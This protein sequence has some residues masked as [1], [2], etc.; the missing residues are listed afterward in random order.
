MEN[1][2]ALL[3]KRSPWDVFINLLAVIALYVC[4]YAV[5]EMLLSFIALAFPDSLDWQWY[6]PRATIR[7]SLALIIIFFPAYVWS[8]RQIETDLAANPE[9]RRWWIRTFPLYLT[10]F[11]AGLLILGDLA[12]F[13][14]SFLNG[15]LTVRFLFK[16]LAILIVGATVM[17]F[18]R[19]ALR[20]EPGPTRGAML[21]FV[22]CALGVVLI[23]VVAGFATTGSPFKTRLERLDA[24][25]L[26]DL[27]EI[28]RHVRDYSREMN[29]LPP[30]IDEVVSSGYF[31]GTSPT[32]RETKTPYVYRVTGPASIELC[33]DFH[34]AQDDEETKEVSFQNLEDW[35]HGAGHVCFSRPIK[36]GRGRGTPAAPGSIP[37]SGAPPR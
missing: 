7:W 16:V 10:L 26:A 14:Y 24:Q 18:Y 3:A 28:E 5:I 23:I 33:A 25:K 13:V 37:P 19:D 30:T 34:T 9:K 4:A 29:Q 8:W 32:D 31:V 27:S 1:N 36:V 20:R 17:V 12:D 15:D 2:G 6:R 21:A 11:L 22:R 35:S